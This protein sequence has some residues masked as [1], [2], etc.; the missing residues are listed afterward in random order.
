MNR[1]ILNTADHVDLAR[2][3]RTLERIAGDYPRTAIARSA[4]SAAGS[5][6]RLVRTNL[7]NTIAVRN[8]EIA[9]RAARLAPPTPLELR[10]MDGDR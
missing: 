3:G 5:I 1:P 7:E 4:R 9:A 10:A 8:A 2:A 6:A